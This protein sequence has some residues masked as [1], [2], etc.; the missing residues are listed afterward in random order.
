MID[1]AMP[2]ISKKLFFSNF[3]VLYIMARLEGLSTRQLKFMSRHPLISEMRKIYGRP[4]LE[5]LLQNT[6]DDYQNN[7]SKMKTFLVKRHPFTR[8]FSGYQNKIL[9]A[10]KGS[11][12]D[13]ISQKILEKYRGL[14]IKKVT[15]NH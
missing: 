3:S 4:S 10:F 8:L 2:S 5:E 1:W 12:H 9:R 13:K 6:H 15:A 7:Q 14:P 11:H